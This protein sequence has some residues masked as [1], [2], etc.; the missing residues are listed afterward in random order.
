MRLSKNFVLS[1]LTRS[2]TAKRLDIKNEPTKYHLENMQRVVTNILQ[3]MRN[4]LGP[5]RV[6]SGYRS[7]QLNRAIGGSLK[8]QHCKGQACDI[9]FWKDGKMCNKEI[10]DWVIDNAVEFDQMINE[11]DFAWIHISLKKDNN[12]REILEAYK[13][14]DGDTKYRHAPDIITL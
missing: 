8:S 14:D 11:F 13:D 2:N 5:I 12:R 10:Y 6:T 9:Q 1:E 7:P 3:P 4:S